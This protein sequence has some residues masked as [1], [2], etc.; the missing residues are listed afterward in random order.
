VMSTAI[1]N[2][3]PN[4]ILRRRYENSGRAIHEI[5][6]GRPAPLADDGGSQLCLSW[7]LRCS[8]FA[9]CGRAATHR[10][11]TVTEVTRIAEML[12]AAGIE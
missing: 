8:C 1:A 2:A 7:H 5:T 4:A 12:T 6:T 11:L 3:M 9:E 10:A